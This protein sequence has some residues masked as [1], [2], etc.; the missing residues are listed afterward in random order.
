MKLP[1]P[2]SLTIVRF[3]A[4]VVF[5]VSAFFLDSRFSILTFL[6]FVV[7]LGCAVVAMRKAR[8][9][10]DVRGLKRLRDIFPRNG[11]R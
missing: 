7:F 4:L 9:Q 5:V 8:K 3:T 10:F 11:G 6:A 1:F 2:S